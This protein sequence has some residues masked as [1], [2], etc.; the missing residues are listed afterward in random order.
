MK[1]KIC[2]LTG[3][4]G[5]T[6]S[7]LAEKLLKE[8]CKVYGM[9]RKSSSFNTQR[10]E[11]I[12]NHS[13]LELVYGDLTDNGSI[14][15]F[16]SKCKPD[17]FFNLGAMSHVKVSFEMPDYTFDAD[18][19]GVIR[20]LEAIRLHSPQTRFLQASTSELFG[21]SPPPQNEQ[22]SF[23]PRSP[24]GVA[25]LAAYWATV[26]YREAYNLFAVNSIS[27]NHESKRRSPTF[28]TMKVVQGFCRIKLGLQK[29]L[30]LGNLDAKRSWN[31]VN[32]IINGMLLII[33]AS[34]PDDYVI[35]S[36]NMISVKNFIEKVASKLEINWQDHVRIDSKY[37][38]P[39]EVDQLEPD[40]SKIKNE[41]GWSPQY[42]LDNIIDEMIEEAMLLARQELLIKN[43]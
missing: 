31:H 11:H 14:N 43:A 15:H 41:L 27:F 24:Y 12:F 42:S 39:S 7:F 25:K 34:K 8:D 26:N 28:L 4:S 38:R 3:I 18:G 19:A 13:N 9:I 37:F 40:A 16:I 17:Y 20:C 1:R 23:H 32:D 5:Q 33:N 30:F 10:I 6:G 36:N 29:E 21:S 2:C 22:T 35:G